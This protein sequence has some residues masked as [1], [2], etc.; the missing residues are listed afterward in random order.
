MLERLE[1]AHAAKVKS[2]FAHLCQLS[3]ADAFVTKDELAYLNKLCTSYNLDK[4]DLDYIMDNAYTIPFS[5]PLNSM[6][7]LEQMYDLVRLVLI[8]ENIDERKVKLCIEVAEKLG[9]KAHIV[10][11]LIKA[12]VNV[13]EETGED[14][15][16]K[17]DLKII[18]KEG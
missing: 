12:L 11:D 9:F 17:D 5:A 13:T 4:T 3:L 10:G 8:D 15:L 1:P 2:H 6:E 7:R 14:T 16:L 18:L